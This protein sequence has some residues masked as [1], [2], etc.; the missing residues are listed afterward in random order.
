M[1]SPVTAFPPRP[2]PTRAPGIVALSIVA[3]GLLAPAAFALGALPGAAQKAAEADSASVSGEESVPGTPLV[4]LDAGV[5]LTSRFIYRGINLGEAPQVQPRVSLNVENFQL[6]LWSSHPIAP[7]TDASENVAIVERGANYREVNFWM[8][9]DFDVGIGTLSPYVQNH[10][11]PNAGD[12]LNFDGGGDGAHFLQG[13]LMFSGHEALPL[14]LMVG[15]VFHNDPERSVY[16]EAG[17][18]FTAGRTDLRVFAGGVPGRSPF[19]G[20]STDEAAVTNIGVSASRTIPL[21]ESY[22]LPL[23]LAFVF[24]PHLEDAFAAVSLSF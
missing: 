3:L 10:Y 1:K 9:Y 13:Q 22:G 20:V 4:R 12:F 2:T 23:G 7:R 14:D 11:N 24:N 17:Y 16:L 8:R 19:N 6:A 18:R 5:T 21:T 15:Y